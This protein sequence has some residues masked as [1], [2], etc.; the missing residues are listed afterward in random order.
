MMLAISGGAKSS[1]LIHHVIGLFCCIAPNVN[2]YRSPYTLR[3]YRM[4]QLLLVA[5]ASTIP[6][7][8]HF[9]MG[10]FG[11]DKMYPRLAKAMLAAFALIFFGTR[12]IGAPLLVHTAVRRGLFDG[13]DAPRALVGGIKGSLYIFIGLNYFWAYKIARMVQRKTR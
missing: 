1:D 2:G 3:L 4:L 13:N 8:L 6:L 5:E 12:N 11:Y 7:N 10:K 9:L